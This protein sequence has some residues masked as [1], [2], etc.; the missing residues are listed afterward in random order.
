MYLSVANSPVYT[1]GWT[2][3]WNL[4]PAQVGV[5]TRRGWAETG[6]NLE[7]LPWQQAHL[8]GQGHDPSPSAYTSR[9][10]GYYGYRSIY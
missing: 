10:T 4:S 5:Y 7:L 1:M 8:N 6:L 9:R 2:R 3:C